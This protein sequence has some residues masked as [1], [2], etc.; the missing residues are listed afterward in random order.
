MKFLRRTVLTNDP[1]LPTHVYL[2]YATVK[3]VRRECP[4]LVIAGHLCIAEHCL[5]QESTWL[6]VAAAARER[7]DIAEQ[8]L[9]QRAELSQERQQHVA[10]LTE[11]NQLPS[12]IWQ[13]C[14][15]NLPLPPPSLCLLSTAAAG[16]AHA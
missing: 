16:C 10:H 11:V 4:S 2:D 15:C 3:S 12:T 14:C 6:Q 8:R 5:R 1:N 7:A 13:P 9:A